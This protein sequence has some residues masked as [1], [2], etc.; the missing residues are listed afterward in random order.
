MRLTD[1]SAAALEIP[2]GKS[3]VLIFDDALPGF[4]LRVRAG[5]KRTW[6]AQYRIGAQQRRVSLGIVGAISAAEARKRAKQD[7]GGAQAGHDVQAKKIT[8][9]AP[10][11]PPGVTLGDLFEMY[12]PVAKEKL[13]PTSYADL[14]RHLRTNWAPLRSLEVKDLERRHIAAELERIAIRGKYEANR[15]RA[16]LS[17]MFSWA[18]GAGRV[19]RD[20]NPVIGTNKATNE[21]ARDRVL[22][23]MEASLIWKQS[24]SGHYAAII[25]LLLLT[26][27]RRE[28]VAAITWSE[29]D[30]VKGL[31]SLPKTRTKNKRAHDVPLSEPAI[32]ILEGLPRQPERDLVF[33][34]GKGAFSGWSK[35]KERFDERL[36]AAGMTA[37][38]RLHDLRRT[39][40]TGMANIGVQPHIVEA[41][42][43]HISGS[44]A[45]V[46]GI[47]NRASYSAE[48]KAALDIWAAHVMAL[49]G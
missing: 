29:I 28:E 21:I 44:R 26:G 16:S 39:V 40:A 10:K 46:A 11:A 37:P 17:A 5:G 38:W 14:V 9:R 20:S 32:A 23:D 1:Q 48:K 36:K 13:K 6:I 31:W 45:G 41:V 25:R 15:S 24:G 22:S 47:Y 18:I 49:V 7:I 19:T 43:N 33:G 34:D 35:C 12:L 27:Q 3:E 8:Q 42:L 4:G 30:L 2:E